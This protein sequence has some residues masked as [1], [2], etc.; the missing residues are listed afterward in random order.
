MT[1]TARPGTSPGP[2]LVVT[3]EMTLRQR[4]DE[5]LVMRRALGFQLDTLEML[6][7]GFCDWL[8]S[9]G[10]TSFT[11]ADA[12][13]WAR[14]PAEANPVWWGMRLGAVRTFA[15]YRTPPARTSRSRPAGSFP[16]GQGG[17]CRSST[18][19]TTWTPSSVPARECSLTGSWPTRC[20]P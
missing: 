16:P 5:Y 20:A 2:V 14:L 19:K 15:A 17:R 1:T 13:T 4:L 7:G 11:T 9:Q 6:A 3:A 8:T 18:P 12:V 10:K